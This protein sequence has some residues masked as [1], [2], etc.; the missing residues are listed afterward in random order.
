[1]KVFFMLA[2]WFFLAEANAQPTGNEWDNPKVSH[3]NREAAHTVSIPMG[4]ETD[5]AVIGLYY[6][7]ITHTEIL[8]LKSGA[9][10]CDQIAS[11][12]IYAILG[13]KLFGNSLIGRNCG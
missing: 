8:R 6:D 2:A 1:M 10:S 3:V 13:K 12:N 7:R 4:S 9:I 5:A 11:R